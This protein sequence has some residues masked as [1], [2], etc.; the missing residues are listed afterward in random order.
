MRQIARVENQPDAGFY[1]RKCTGNGYKKSANGQT[2]A[3]IQVSPSLKYCRIKFK[4]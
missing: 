2:S 4:R 1:W 3:N